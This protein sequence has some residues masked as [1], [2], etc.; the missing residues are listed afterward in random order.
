MP[1][2]D[3]G[4]AILERMLA[5]LYSKADNDLKHSAKEV[6]SYLMAADEQFLGSIRVDKN[7]TESI[8]N[9]YGPYGSTYSPTSVF[10]DYCPYGGQYGRF[11]P[12]NPY[13][14]TPPKLF[15]RGK[16]RGNVSTNTFVSDFISWDTFVYLL[17]NDLRALLKGEFHNSLANVSTAS[18]DTF[19]QASDDTFLGSLNPN[20]LD[21]NSIFNTFGQYGNKFSQTCIFNKYSVYGTRFSPLS[22]FN[23]FT[24][25]PPRIM[26][27]Q[28]Q[29]AFLTVSKL[30]KPAVD[31]NTIKEWASRHVKSH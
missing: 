30:L 3:E 14:G 17:R 28:K 2:E 7:D 25:T 21:K 16:F 4:K 15:I 9:Q 5:E 13:T 20:R 24:T 19:I 12:Q 22:P 10:N 18:G 27:G 11:S 31:P 29:V 6:D 1:E 23:K 8:L 26:N